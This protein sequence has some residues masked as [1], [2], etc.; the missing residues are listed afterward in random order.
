MIGQSAKKER[1]S[2]Q[3]KEITPHWLRVEFSGY[4]RYRANQEPQ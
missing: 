1:C 4:A 3:K 2:V